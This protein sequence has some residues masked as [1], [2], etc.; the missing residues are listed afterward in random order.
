ME[1]EKN[2]ISETAKLVG[3]ENHV[4]RYWEEELELDIYRNEVG[5]RFYTLKDINTFKKIKNWK[6]KGLQLK[7]IKGML[8]IHKNENI[9]SIYPYE[10]NEHE[11]STEDIKIQRL[12]SILKNMMQEAVSDALIDFSEELTKE[13]KEEIR[14]EFERKELMDREIMKIQNERLEKHFQELDTRLREVSGKKRKKHSI[15]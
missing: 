9:V 6:E 12:Q 5:H 2:T 15:F 11:V 4:L 10:R 13:I 3:V 1:K 7:A 14:Y 8:G